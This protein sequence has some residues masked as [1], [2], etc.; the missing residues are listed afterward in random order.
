MSG[1][2]VRGGCVGVDVWVCASS[3]YVWVGEWVI[4]HPRRPPRSHDRRMEELRPLRPRCRRCSFPPQ[5]RHLMPRLQWPES[6]MTMGDTYTYT[7]GP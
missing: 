3:G 4:P 2:D 1:F 7:R 6:T 5:R